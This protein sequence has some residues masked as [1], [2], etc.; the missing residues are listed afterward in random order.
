VAYDEDHANEAAVNSKTYI[1]GNVA[2]F[3]ESRRQRLAVLETLDEKPTIEIS[4]LGE[5]CRVD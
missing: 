5:S 1:P 3:A 4:D 2:V